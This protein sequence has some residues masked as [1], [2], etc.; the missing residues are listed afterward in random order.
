MIE[1]L[2]DYRS[3]A[4]ACFKGIGATEKNIDKK[5]FKLLLQDTT[6]SSIKRD[7]LADLARMDYFLKYAK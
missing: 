4:I 1:S 2:K 6:I 5:A 3:K 7:N